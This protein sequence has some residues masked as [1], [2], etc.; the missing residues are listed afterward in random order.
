VCLKPYASS[1]QCAC[2]IF[3][4]VACPALQYF[5]ILFHKRHYFLKKNIYNKKCMFWFSLQLLS[6][7]YFILG[8]NE[9]DVIKNVAGLR[10]K[11]PLFLSDFYENP[12]NGNRIDPCGQMD[13]WT[14]G[15]TDEHDKANSR[16]SNFAN[17]PRNLSAS[18]VSHGWLFNRTKYPRLALRI[19]INS[20]Q[21]VASASEGK[22]QWLR[23]ALWKE[24]MR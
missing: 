2:A 14:D 21:S 5:C 9:R 19:L 1:M 20:C 13:G 15:R 12:S 22:A 8:R 11:C 17:A 23:I 7:T 18:S 24:S 10:V 3:S 16:I 4:S 6:G